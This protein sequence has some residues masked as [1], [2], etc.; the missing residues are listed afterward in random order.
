M[1]RA[2][3]LAVS[4]ILF[5]ALN[6][7]L[8]IVGIAQAQLSIPTFTGKFTL[9]TQVQWDKT[10]LQ[11]GDYTVTM[12]SISVP[13]AAL[14]R[15]HSGRPVGRFIT[16]IDS[17]KPARG[18]ALLIAEKGGQPHVYSLALGGL[19]RVLVYDP[20]LAREAALEARVP[21]K[22]PVILARR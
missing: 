18:N 3:G 11:P 4:R 8:I 13:T 20:A 2:Q 7:G 9:N 1:K 19:G 15:D 22:V 10:V 6:V 17:G 12:E 21:Q 5:A 16:T 14:I